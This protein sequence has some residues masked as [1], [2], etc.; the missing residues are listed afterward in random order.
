MK[1]DIMPLSSRFLK[2]KLRKHSPF[3][4]TNYID[5]TLYMVYR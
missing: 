1:I 5:F 4:A 3:L 2:E